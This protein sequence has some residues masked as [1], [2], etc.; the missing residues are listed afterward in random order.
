MSLFFTLHARLQE[1]ELKASPVDGRKFNRRSQAKM[2]RE[3]RAVTRA[4]NK[5]ARARA[6]KRAL[7]RGAFTAEEVREGEEEKR[8]FKEQMQIKAKNVQGLQ[9]TGGGDDAGAG[10]SSSPGPE[11]TARE[12]LKEP[13]KEPWK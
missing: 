7:I 9:Q 6:S 3:A 1:N 12:P 13:L 2:N 8:R 4:I 10:P 5:S 11:E